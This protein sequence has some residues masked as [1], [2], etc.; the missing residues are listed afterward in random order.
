MDKLPKRKVSASVH[1]KTN[2]SWGG[3][4]SWYDS[5]LEQ[6]LDTYQKAVIL[7][8]LLR[9]L[10]LKK[11]EKILDLASGQ[12]FF[13][14]EFAKAGALVTGAEIA[15]ELVA[16]AKERSAEVSNLSYEI[17]SA[18]KLVFAKNES[19]DVVVCVL[20]LQNMENLSGVVAEAARVLTKIGRLVLVLNHPAFR[21]PRR[22]N[23]GYDEKTGVQFR[24]IDAYL[25]GSRVN[26]EMNPGQ[27]EGEKT[28]S[29]HHSLQD[30]FKV[31]SKNGLVVTK[32][33][34]WISHKE[35]AKGPRQ[36]AEDQ[37]R[38]E[39]PLFLMLELKK[40]L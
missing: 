31:F 28:I 23:W 17:A 39:I 8:N 11:G 26:I 3:V 34:E 5:H 25:S 37:A 40:S 13:S 12:G 29:Y 38:K 9:V 18:D 24:R 36:K 33:E 21:I 35:S 19:F 16:L 32:L 7:P 2:T 15:T 22:S 30:F 1:K 27:K 6:N 4:A 10:S 20:A 14:R